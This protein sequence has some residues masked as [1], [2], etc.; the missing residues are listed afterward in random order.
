MSDVIQLYFT[1]TIVVNSNSGLQSA[2]F[3]CMNSAK[4]LD[5]IIPIRYNAGAFV[6]DF[7]AFGLLLKVT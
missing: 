2:V 6:L 3:F 4:R 7:K 5:R 1:E